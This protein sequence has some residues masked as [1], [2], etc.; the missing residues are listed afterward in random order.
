M[1]NVQ[2]G[3]LVAD[4]GGNIISTSYLPQVQ[5]SKLYSISKQISDNFAM[6]C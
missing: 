5:K 2:G 6:S 4:A 1:S 3:A